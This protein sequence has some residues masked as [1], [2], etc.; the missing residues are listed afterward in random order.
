MKKLLF[1]LTVVLVIGFFV[2]CS[3]GG[4]GD[5]DTPFGGLYINENSYFPPFNVATTEVH[6]L[7]SR[8]YENKNDRDSAVEDFQDKGAY[9][10]YM[11]QTRRDNPLS[12]VVLA[13]TQIYSTSYDIGM[14]I[15]I[16][17]ADI[18]RNDGLF[19]T[20]FGD[21]DAPIINVRVDKIFASDITSQLNTYGNSLE[22]N[23]FNPI[24]DRH[25]QKQDLTNHIIYAWSYTS[26]GKSA[27]WSTS[28]T[29]RP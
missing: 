2:G 11:N 27:A 21:T 7:I 15:R 8:F 22:G 3:G 13:F 18:V 4:G 16:N 19:E 28:K 14:E 29:D 23:G 5:T 10:I 17:G 26:G 6:H 9:L 20:I 25:W 24:S 1:S 12:N